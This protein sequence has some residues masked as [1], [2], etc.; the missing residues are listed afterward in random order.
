MLRELVLILLLTLPALQQDTLDSETT[1]DGV[2][3]GASDLPP[4]DNPPSPSSSNGGTGGGSGSADP[5]NSPDFSTAQQITQG[6]NNQG[7]N[8]GTTQPATAANQDWSFIQTGTAPRT[9][10]KWRTPSAYQLYQKGYR[11]TYTIKFYTDCPQNPVNFIFAT[12]GYSFVYLNGKLIH[13]WGK[14]YPEYHTLTLT[15]DNYLQCGC[16]VLKVIVYNYCCPSPCGLTYSLTQNKA[17][18]YECNN[19]GL[20]HYNRNTCQCECV[21]KQ[22]CGNPLRSWHDYPTCGC[23]CTKPLTCPRNQY[24]NWKTCKCECKGKCCPLGQK[25]NPF[26][27]QCGCERKP[28]PT[29]QIWDSTKCKCVCQQRLCQRPFIWDQ[30]Q[31]GCVCPSNIQVTC[32]Q[33][34]I[35]DRTRCAC[36]C[37][38]QVTCPGNQYWDRNSCSCKCRQQQ[39][40]SPY[41]WNPSSC[42]CECPANGNCQW[43]QV[44]N[45]TTCRCQCPPCQGTTC[46]C[47]NCVPC[48]AGY[49]RA[50]NYNCQCRPATQCQAQNCINGW[51]WSYTTCNCVYGG[52]GS[53]QGGIQGSTAGGV[54]GS[55][56]GG[57]TGGI[58]GSSAGGS[59]NVGNGDTLDS[60]ISVGN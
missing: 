38:A 22:A 55:S 40:Q 47:N 2:D 26:T 1:A 57:S 41:F 35:W 32:P 53:P 3:F 18:C 50:N 60:S 52:V 37:S 9:N 30:N 16:N 42:A 31:C 56:Q 36:V 17:G 48:P 15:K 59:Q 12:T 6:G 10:T 28:C 43:P 24:F 34:H 54:D 7:T 19:T 39:C 21:E 4:F 27:C 44:W 58:D 33:N 51:T 45:R 11:T 49:V 20:S 46:P 5:N 23:K 25:Q 14:P 8:Q 13:K 29:G